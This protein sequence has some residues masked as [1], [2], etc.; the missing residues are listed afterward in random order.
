MKILLTILLAA[1][2]IT[3]W[4]LKTRIFC[5]ECGAEMPTIEILHQHIIDEHDGKL[6]V[7]GKMEA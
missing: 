2:T 7:H 4:P 5:F 3:C 6:R 1:I